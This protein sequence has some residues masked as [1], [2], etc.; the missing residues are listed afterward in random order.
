MPHIWYKTRFKRRSEAD[1]ADA[2]ITYRAA[3]FTAAGNS[4]LANSSS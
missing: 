4:T 3:S 1:L 2:N